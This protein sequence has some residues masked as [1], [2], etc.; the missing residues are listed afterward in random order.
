MCNNYR[1]EDKYYIDT[2]KLD[3]SAYYYRERRY[4]RREE[5]EQGGIEQ[6][7]KVMQAV[8]KAI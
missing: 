7:R 2:E 5:D 1:E 3:K 8:G 6:E 4:I